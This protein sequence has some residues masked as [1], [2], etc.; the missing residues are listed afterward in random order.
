MWV[1]EVCPLWTKEFPS[2]VKIS[3]DYTS[4]FEI[5]VYNNLKLRNN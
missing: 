3:N 5:V 1:L 2:W 4:Q